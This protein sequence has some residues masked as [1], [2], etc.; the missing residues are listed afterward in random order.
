MECSFGNPMKR[1]LL[2][3][4]LENDPA[5]KKQRVS[6]EEEEENQC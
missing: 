1:K 6:C 2:C 4:S 5:Q 3:L